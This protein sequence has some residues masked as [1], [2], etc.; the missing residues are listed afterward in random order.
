MAVAA[1]GTV[2]LQLALMRVPFC[3]I[4]RLAG[5][6]YWLA[7]LLVRIPR[8]CLANIVAGEELAVELIQE[9]ATPE[10]V[11]ETLEPWLDDPARLESARTRMQVIAERLGA[12][13][14][15]R[16]LADCIE[17]TISAKS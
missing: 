17:E 6:S 8:V 1:S 4:Y 10:R 5:L 11:V 7:R 3:M 12:P 14:G 16:R 13:V 15:M 2:T 9:H